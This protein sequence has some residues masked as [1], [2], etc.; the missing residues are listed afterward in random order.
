MFRKYM[1]AIVAVLAL[2]AGAQADLVITTG[3]W[4][5]DAGPGMQVPLN[6]TSGAPVDVAGMT[7]IVQIGDGG[8]ELEPIVGGPRTD[9]PSIMGLDILAPGALFA[10]AGGAPNIV[11]NYPQLRSIQVTTPTGTV[12]AGTGTLLGMLTIDTSGFAGQSFALSL[13]ATLAGDTQLNASDGVPIALSIFNGSIHVNPLQFMPDLNMDGFV[14]IF[15]INLVSANWGGPG[16]A[17]DANKDGMVNIFDINL[18]SANWSPAPGAGAVAAVPE[19]ASWMLL[20][21]GLAV[22]VLIGGVRLSRSRALAETL[23]WFR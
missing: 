23:A 17:G 19:P 5:F 1:L 2:A 16:P 12:S 6:I 18:I 10:T 7:L 4:T 11:D 3:D 20:V 13:G 15:D 22:A 21:C 14:D 8:P 9:G